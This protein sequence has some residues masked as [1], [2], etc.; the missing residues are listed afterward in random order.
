MY[1]QIRIF[2]NFECFPYLYSFKFSTNILCLEISW[3]DSLYSG[4]DGVVAEQPP[5]Y[6]V[7]LSNS[8]VFNQKQY[9]IYATK[10]LMRD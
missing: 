6:Y 9:H 3:H 4:F 8:R 10:F 1:T 7:T 2:I 5:N